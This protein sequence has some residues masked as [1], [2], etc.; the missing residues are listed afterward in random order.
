MTEEDYYQTVKAAAKEVFWHDLNLDEAS[1]TYQVEARDIREAVEDM[2]ESLEE[3]GSKI[4][5]TDTS[6]RRV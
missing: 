4:I 2:V 6:Y 5:W 3:E 1:D